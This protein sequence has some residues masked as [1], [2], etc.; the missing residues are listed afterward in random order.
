MQ[1]VS[2]VVSGDNHNTDR[3]GGMSGSRFRE[4]GF[5]SYE[6]ALS[7]AKERADLAT[8]QGAA[9]LLQ[10]GDAGDVYSLTVTDQ[11]TNTQDR[12]A[13]NLVYKGTG[14]TGIWG[15]NGL[16]AFAGKKYD[17]IGNWTLGVISDDNN[18]NGAD[19]IAKYF[20]ATSGVRASTVNQ[21]ADNLYYSFDI[22]GGFHGVVLNTIGE[23]ATVDEW[24]YWGGGEE[25]WSLARGGNQEFLISATQLDWLTA[26]LAANRGKG[27]VIFSHQPISPSAIANRDDAGLGGFGTYYTLGNAE[28]II[29]VLAS[30]IS[31]GGDIIASIAGHHH[32]GDQAFWQSPPTAN[33]IYRDASLSQEVDGNGITYVTVRCPIC[34]GGDSVDAIDL[35]TPNQAYGLFTVGDMG[36]GLPRLRVGGFGQNVAQKDYNNNRYLIS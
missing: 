11:G 3:A 12:E 30:E 23:N 8:A 10:T 28:A 6:T 25:D 9:F 29:T 31:A 33:I 27:I 2:F 17:V 26:D 35:V 13:I 36:E 4:S 24:L 18:A 1:P 22:G 20:A 7:N 32:P 14:A 19:G 5:R 15:T 34:M 16:G 21:G